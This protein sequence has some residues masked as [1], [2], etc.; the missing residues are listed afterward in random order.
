VILL[1]AFSASLSAC[2]ELI[3]LWQPLKEAANTSYLTTLSGDIF[4]S[5]IVP[6][7]SPDNKELYVSINECEFEDLGYDMFYEVATK[8]MVSKKT[9]TES[10]SLESFPRLEIIMPSAR[11]DMKIQV[12]M[13]CYFGITVRA[14][15]FNS[16]LM[17]YCLLGKDRNLISIDEMPLKTGLEIDWVFTGN[18]LAGGLGV[19]RVAIFDDNQVNSYTLWTKTDLDEIAAQ[20]KIDETN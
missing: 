18:F 4:W 16:Y 7:L 20:Q 12:D 8:T 11:S 19:H 14:S 6:Y 9:A 15:I 17:R 3:H 1:F 2:D 13:V 5:K 10:Q